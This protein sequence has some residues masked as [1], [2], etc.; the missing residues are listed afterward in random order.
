[1][2]RLNCIDITHQRR[3]KNIRARV[4]EERDRIT[5]MVAAIDDTMWRGRKEAI[6]PDFHDVAD[7]DDK[8]ICNGRSTHPLTVLI[9]NLKTPN[10]VLPQDGECTGVAVRQY[11]DLIPALGVWLGRIVIDEFE[12]S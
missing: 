7:I 4:N 8:G 2:K 12:F 3:N 9:L 11:A 1:M 5:V 6:A 10:F